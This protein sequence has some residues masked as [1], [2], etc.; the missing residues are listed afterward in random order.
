MKIFLR[1]LS[2]LL[3]LVV[4]LGFATLQRVD[5]SPYEQTD[6][7]RQTL[8]GLLAFR[9]EQ[10]VDTLT[11]NWASASLIPPFGSPMAG[12]GDREGAHFEGVKD[13]LFV[14]AVVFR[15][16]G[17]KAAFLTA[18]LL[19]IPPELTQRL[20]NQ[21]PLIGWSADELYL[22][23]THTHGSVGAWAPG[24]IGKLFAG[25]YNEEMITFLAAQFMEAIRQADQNHESISMA[26]GRIPMPEFVTNRLVGLD[27]DTD[28]ML[29]WMAL[30]KSGGDRMVLVAFGA[31]ATCF[32][33]DE[34]SLH[35]DYPGM[36]REKLSEEGIE[37]FFAAGAVGSQAPGFSELGPS[38]QAEKM[39]GGL[40]AALSQSLQ[41]AVFE[42]VST[43][44]VLSL[45][46]YTAKPQWRISESLAIKPWLFHKLFGDY[47]LRMKALKLGELLWVGLPCDFSAEL[48]MPLYE[49]AGHTLF[50]SSFNG[51][52]MGYVT[53]DRHYSLNSYETRMMNWYG[54][55]NG[56]YFS[57]L[58][59]Q[60]DKAM[61]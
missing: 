58:I 21:L 36:L 59:L 30:K 13:S 2:F 53:H 22:S 47:P 5:H 12:Y 46:L 51:G 26:F 20:E 3:L 55:G 23:A 43:L 4:G 8:D 41:E 39:A 10:D 11:S 38:A 40:S 31:H 35:G 56:A 1:L 6:Y 32:G 17:R 57:D 25:A 52:Y 44:Q 7:Y 60:V 15:Q 42:P 48:S 24:P 50:V 9:A 29:N 33:P 34:M 45:P 49:A 18:D 54:P 16:A 28:P 61:K 19:I 27:G 14:H 37:G